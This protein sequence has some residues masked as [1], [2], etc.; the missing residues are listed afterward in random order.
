MNITTVKKYTKVWKAL[1]YYV[2]WAE[3][4]PPENRPVYRL[5]NAQR[6][7]LENLRRKIDRF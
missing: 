3:N 4:R 5:T 6:T 1:L 7:A 2:F